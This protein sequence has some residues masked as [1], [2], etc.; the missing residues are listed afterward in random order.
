MCRAKYIEQKIHCKN[1]GKLQCIEWYRFDGHSWTD[2]MYISNYQMNKYI[3]LYIS[4]TYA[5]MGALALEK[6][7]QGQFFC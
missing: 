4:M 1:I 2:S 7:I 3:F 6:Y 5:D